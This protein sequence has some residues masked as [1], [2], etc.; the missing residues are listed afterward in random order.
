MNNWPI[1]P[2]RVKS[3]KKLAERV[4]DVSWP[5]VHEVIHYLTSLD[6]FILRNSRAID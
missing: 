1:P 2:P 4:Q 5:S 3:D 6:S